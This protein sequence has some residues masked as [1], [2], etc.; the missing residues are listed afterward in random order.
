MF[1]IKLM[2][3]FKASVTFGHQ[4]EHY[5]SENSV[6]QFVLLMYDTK[7]QSNQTADNLIDLLL[8]F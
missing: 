5:L 4:K 1:F 7:L 8:M 6:N 2:I 3:F